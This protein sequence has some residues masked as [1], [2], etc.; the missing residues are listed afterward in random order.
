LGGGY[1][2]E[3]RCGGVEAERMGEGSRRMGL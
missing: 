1:E 3:G 2:L